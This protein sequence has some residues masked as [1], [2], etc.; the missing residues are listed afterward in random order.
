M[1]DEQLGEQTARGGELAGEESTAR[2]AGSEGVVGALVAVGATAVGVVVV[3]VVVVGVLAVDVMAGS[4][5]APPAGP[6]GA[7]T[8]CVGIEVAG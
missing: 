2:V 4:A 5:T 1:A 6:V 3:G 8:D 7:V